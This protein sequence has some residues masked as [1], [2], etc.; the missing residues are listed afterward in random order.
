MNQD[1]LP[2]VLL[3]C[4][5][6]FFGNFVGRGYLL[7]AAL[8]FTLATEAYN[9]LV[10]QR[11]AHFAVLLGSISVG[12]LE[13]IL[14]LQALLVLCRLRQLVIIDLHLE[15]VHVESKLASSL[16]R[17]LLDPQV[18][19]DLDRQ[20]GLGWT[21]SHQFLFSLL[22]GDALMAFDSARAAVTSV[23][24]GVKCSILL[25]TGAIL[26]F[27]RRLLALH[28]LLTADRLRSAQCEHVART[29]CKR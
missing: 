21:M 12:G 25:L 8:T 22:S 15:H 2:I 27:K 28:R 29:L 3:T 11:T 18:V 1:H 9:A 13:L 6:V 10:L 23:A 17:I 19:V 16:A 5:T 7:T 14:T 20:C 4:A 26:D 24:S